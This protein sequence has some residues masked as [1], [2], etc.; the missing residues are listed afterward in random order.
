[1]ATVVVAALVALS[2]AQMIQY[3]LGI[4]PI[5]DTTW[6]QYRTLFLRFR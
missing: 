6:E 4:L 1:V 3:W 2:C 5:T